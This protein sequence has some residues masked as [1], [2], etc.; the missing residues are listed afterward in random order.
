VHLWD[1][2]TRSRS[3]ATL[4]YGATAIFAQVPNAW[5]LQSASSYWGINLNLVFAP[6]PIFTCCKRKGTVGAMCTVGNCIPKDVPINK[7]CCAGE[8]QCLSRNV[9]HC[10][11]EIFFAKNL[12]ASFLKTTYRLKALLARS[13]SIDSNFKRKQLGD[14]MAA[15]ADFF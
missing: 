12:G 7:Q 4:P 3:V 2:K 1:S 15:M 6:L 10:V 8:L 11:D 14:K 13:I 9:V 5:S